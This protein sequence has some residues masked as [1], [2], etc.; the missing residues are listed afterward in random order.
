M[1]GK[2]TG[3]YFLEMKITSRKDL[4]I[5]C[6]CYVDELVKEE[7]ITEDHS[8]Y[9]YEDDEHWEEEQSYDAH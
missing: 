3:K 1:A 2:R 7:D 4:L 8:A 6:L 9:N 5:L